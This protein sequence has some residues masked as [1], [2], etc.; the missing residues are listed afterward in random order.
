MATLTGAV[1]LAL[2]DGTS[3]ST[4]PQSGVTVYSADGQKYEYINDFF[5][6]SEYIVVADGVSRIFLNDT[7]GSSVIVGNDNVYIYAEQGDNKVI[8]GAGNNVVSLGDGDD[9]IRVT[10]GANRVETGDGDDT[11]TAGDGNNT[12]ISGNG[13]DIIDAGNGN[14]V[15][16]SGAGNDVIQVGQG[17]NTIVAGAGEDVIVITGNG[18]GANLIDAGAGNDAIYLKSGAGVDKI[19]KGAAGDADQV[20]GFNAGT[21]VDKIVAGAGLDSQ[22]TESP[23]ASITGTEDYSVADDGHGNAVITF[24]DGTT[25]TLV[26]VAATNVDPSDFTAS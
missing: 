2:L 12:I 25:V 26:G 19:V 4:E 3:I 10:T 18:A 5:P 9:A 24:A 15:I 17:N 21:S 20:S 1:Q 7:D 13:N 11:V 6:G 14:N 22:F 23:D 16:D 8:A